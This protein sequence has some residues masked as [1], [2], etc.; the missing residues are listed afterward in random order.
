[1]NKNTLVYVLSLIAT[2]MLPGIGFAA[3]VSKKQS[4]KEKT[5]IEQQRE[6]SQSLVHKMMGNINIAQFAL[7]LGLP[8][9]AI[10]HIEKAQTIEAQLTSQS[11]KLKVD[12][13][14]RYGKVTYDDSD[15][16]KEYYVPV[17]DDILLINDYEAIFERSEEKGLIV[18]D[19]GV[20]HVGVSVDLREVKTGL[21][22][23]L[24]DI[25][26][27]EFSNAQKA[28]DGVFKGAIIDEEEIDDPILAISENLALAKSFLNHRQ[29]DNARLTLKYVQKR[30]DSAEEADFSG[31]DKDSV[32]KLSTDLDKLQ[33][34]LRKKDPTMTQR[35]N[36]R[37]D[38]W[39]K[40]IAGWYQST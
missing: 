39:S 17:V 21:D 12:S 7:G 5:P 15:T 4:T 38:H 40:T 26:K 16:I 18:T 13:S 6:Q 10:H 14:F 35:I 23:A 34:D 8:D 25:N 37:F 11:P 20:V 30:L 29:Y 31:T 2:F 9:D 28:L 3:D 1:M 33:T 32:K 22:T 19:A 36:D 24:K 27:K